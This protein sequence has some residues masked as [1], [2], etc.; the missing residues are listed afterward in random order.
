MKK[1]TTHTKVCVVALSL[2][3]ELVL[4]EQPRT[5]H[6]QRTRDQIGRL[7]CIEIF[8]SSRATGPED[9]R[10]RGRSTCPF[11]SLHSRHCATRVGGTVLISVP[12]T[13]G[14]DA[15]GSRH[16]G[17]SQPSR[18]VIVSYVRLVRPSRRTKGLARSGKTRG[19]LAVMDE[20][21][22]SVL[23]ERADRGDED[24]VDQLIELASEEGN[25]E[26]LR[27]LADQ[28][29]TTASDQLIELASEQGNLEELR[30]LADQGNTTAS[31]QLI[32]LASEQGNLE[33]L[34]RLADQGNTTASEMLAEL[35]E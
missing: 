24:A 12:L 30:R 20:L 25:L 15:T 6:Q 5:D 10:I 32:E 11:P 17:V 8:G 21:D 34:R 13:D 7:S 1:I 28:G 33:E 9:R 2:S 4:P 26:E 29:N 23:R 27:R 3:Y 18:I 35:E 19:R 14:G 22:L 16:G 31:D